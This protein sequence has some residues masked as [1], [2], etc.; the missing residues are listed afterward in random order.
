MIC[1]VVR[2]VRD[3]RTVGDLVQVS[4]PVVVVRNRACARQLIQRVVLIGRCRAINRHRIAVARGIVRETG[5]PGDGVAAVITL[6]TLQ[7]VEVVILPLDIAAAKLGHFLAI[8]SAIQFVFE[9]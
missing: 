4:A 9:R 7:P 3:L 6:F 8:A 5:F 2:V 1:R